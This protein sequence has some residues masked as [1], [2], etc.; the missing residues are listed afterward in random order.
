MPDS[1]SDAGGPHLEQDERPV[2]ETPPPTTAD[3]PFDPRWWGAVTLPVDAVARWQAGPSTLHAQRRAAD[4]RVWQVTEP[5]AYAVAAQRVRRVDEPPPDGAPQ[6]RFT[7]AE[8]PDT[9]TVTPELADRPVIVRPEASLTVPPGETVTLYVSSPVWMVLKVEVR[10]ARRGR[11]RPEPVVLAEIPTYRPSDTW[12]GPSTRVGELCYSVRTA[13]RLRVSELPLRPHRAVTPVTVENQAATAL[14][15][16]RV[17]VPMQYLALHVDRAGRLWS[18][19]VLFTR[20]PDEDTGVK[21]TPYVPDGGERLADPR[22]PQ[23][24]GQV[25]SK[26][27]NRLFKGNH[28]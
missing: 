2:V 22:T 26:T 28:R 4:W 3:A 19:G 11:T 18:D 13:A 15:L 5:D 24:F 12:F 25:L 14:Q 9:I 21:V 7:F 1:I 16:S 17:S 8:T 10:R 6:L 20:Q 23:G 27:V